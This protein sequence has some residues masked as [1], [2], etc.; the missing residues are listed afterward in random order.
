M[1]YQERVIES[2][3]QYGAVNARSASLETLSMALCG[4][5]FAIVAFARSI[6]GFVTGILLLA[7]GLGFIVMSL[8]RGPIAAV[9]IAIMFALMVL[10]FRR[11]FRFM[12]V[13][14]AAVAINLGAVFLFFPDVAN[15]IF[16]NVIER[17]ETFEKLQADKSLKSRLSEYETL[18]T[19]HVPASPIIGHGFG[20]R[21]KFYDKAFQRTTRAI[22]M[23]NGYIYPFYKFGLGVGLFFLMALFYPVGRLLIVDRRSLSREHHQFLAGG[24]AVLV[25]LL[26]SNFTSMN[27]LYYV[28]VVL[29][30]LAFAALDYVTAPAA[31]RV[32]IEQATTAP[33]LLKRGVA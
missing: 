10:P 28:D 25:S 6:R 14:A 3:L 30:T 5:A 1:N 27:I 23:H 9:M 33:A 26:V 17:V 31:R 4:I 2:A 19:K 13:A 16:E 32:R 20:V 21:Y 29:Y 7:A 12:F 22:F 24:V 15:S 8:S 18:V 11:S